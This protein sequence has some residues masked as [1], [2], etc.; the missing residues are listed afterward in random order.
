MKLNL[1]LSFFIFLLIVGCVSSQSLVDSHKSE[2]DRGRKSIKMMMAKEKIPG[3]A[4]AVSMEGETIWKEGFGYSDLGPM[5]RVSPDTSQFRIGSI[6]K[7]MT[8]LGMAILYEQG[9]LDLD[10]EIQEYVPE[11]PRKKYPI[12]VRQVASH[13]AGIRHYKGNE[14]KSNKAYA[15]VKEGLSIFK[16]DPLEHKPN[17]KYLYSSY[18]W[19][20]LSV[21]VESASKQHFLNFMQQ[22]I[23]DPLELDMTCADKK[24]SVV[25]YRT[26]FYSIDRKK[27][28]E[29][30][31]V[32]NSHKWA[33]GGFLSTANDVL[34]F[35][36]G[37]LNHE[38][39]EKET[40]DLFLKNQQMTNGKMTYY[41]L[42]WQL[43]KDG[44]GYT[45]YGHS[46][47]AMGGTS[48]LLIQ[49]EK[50]IVLVMLTNLTGADL[51]DTLKLIAELFTK[52]SEA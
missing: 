4:I 27:I 2:I 21:V 48:Q 47:G 43:W 11:F 19:N 30:T 6:S 8:A 49:P 38:L 20:L 50:E 39:I 24:D 10:A 13:L 17:S 22:K 14:F 34:K 35:G 29:A 9:K 37:A 45:W 28:V 3:L 1:K 18:G 32:D 40:M 7:S 5:Q 26:G 51:K 12:T 15:S 23:F 33:G 31:E 44:N 16:D 36:E 46:G 41:G 42:G 52:D 25:T